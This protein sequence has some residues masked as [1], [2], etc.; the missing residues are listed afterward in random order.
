MTL[1]PVEDMKSFVVAVT[2]YLLPIFAYSNQHEHNLGDH[3]SLK[4]PFEDELGVLCGAVV[5]VHA[6]RRFYR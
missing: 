5:A 3:R 6:D 2:R 1:H 4:H